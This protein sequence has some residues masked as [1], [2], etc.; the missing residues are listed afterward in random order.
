MNYYR[1][2]NIIIRSSFSFPFF[3]LFF[4]S[5]QQPLDSRKDQ[6]SFHIKFSQKRGVLFFAKGWKF[7]VWSQ[8]KIKILIWNQSFVLKTYKI[9]NTKFKILQKSSTPFATTKVWFSNSKELT[10][11]WESHVHGIQYWLDYSQNSTSLCDFLIFMFFI[12]KKSFS[13]RPFSTKFN[14]DIN[15]WFCGSQN[16]ILMGLYCMREMWLWHFC[17]DR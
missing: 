3:S 11:E 5:Y 17:W 6:I 1:D 4:T 8:H 14:A 10:Q 2:E 15:K 9:K 13:R 7:L 12:M 16:W